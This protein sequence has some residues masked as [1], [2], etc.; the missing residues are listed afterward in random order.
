MPVNTSGR[1]TLSAGAAALALAFSALAIAAPNA[2]AEP[3]N[4]GSGG[5]EEKGGSDSTGIY[6]AAQIQYS[7]SVAKGGGTG[8]VTSTDVNWTPP[9]C[10]YAP[11]LGAKDFKA[12]MSKSIED[13]LNTPGMGGTAGSALGQAKSHYEDGFGWTDTPGYKDYNVDKDGKGMFWAGVEN[14]NEPDVLKRSACSDLPFWVDNGEAPPPQYEQAIRPEILA[15]LAYQHMQLPDTKVTLAPAANT[16]VNLPT[17]AW[18]DK[19]VFNEVQATAALNA[20]G[21]N[22]Q[23]TTTA[24]PV[25]LKLEPGTEDAQVYPA[26]GECA[27]NADDSIGEPYAQGKASQT[28]PCGIKYLRSSG[29]GTYQL[30]ATI[31]WHITWTGTGVPGGNLPDGTFGSE[32]A[33]TVQEIQAVNR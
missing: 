2:F 33:I 19:A 20:P 15:G 16:K 17:W 25:S 4:T 32:Q 23:A 29:E 28:P 22:I 31:T 8:N 12:K 9:A 7:G 30:R 24:K 21:L 5:T 14:P 1:T 10:W 26:S 11:Y 13:Q 18:L 6:A 27:I 3:V